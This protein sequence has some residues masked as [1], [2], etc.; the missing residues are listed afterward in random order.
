VEN[1]SGG[2]SN[3]DSP[4]LG[5]DVDCPSV[6]LAPRRRP[7]VLRHGGIDSALEQAAAVAG[8]E[9]IA[10]KSPSLAQQYLNAGLL[11]RIL[12]SVVPIL[13]GDGVRFFGALTQAPVEVECLRVAER[14][15]AT[16]LSYRVCGSRRGSR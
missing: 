16:H 1:T 7:G 11:D 5:P 3:R 2:Y 8:D 13:L 15:G 14:P 4:P 9:P 6:R 12:V 10:V